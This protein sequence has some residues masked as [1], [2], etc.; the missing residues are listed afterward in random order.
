M[1]AK[2]LVLVLS[3]I[4]LICLFTGYGVFAQEKKVI[5][6]GSPQKTGHILVDAS[7]KFKEL[8]EKGSGGRIEVQVQPGVT[9][10]EEVNVWCSKGKVE[11]QAA[12]GRPLEVSAPQYFFFNAPYVMKDFDHFM[13][14]WEGNL[15]KKARE[16]LEKNGNQVS[17]GIVYRGLRQT[18]SKKPLY[19]PVDVYG[20]KLRLPPVKTWIAVWKEIGA[21]PISIPL[22]ELYKSLKEGKA[23][24]SEGDLPQI[25]SFK[26]DEV[27]THLTITNHQVQAG[28]ITINKTFFDGLSKADQQ[29][30]LKSAKDA[31]NWANDKIKKGESALLLELQ[32]KGMQVVIPDAESFREKG[33]PAVEELFKKEWPVTTWA[34]V[35]AK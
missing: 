13:R 11:I 24:A 32:R 20:L 33:K 5:R 29:L 19:T 2:R 30:I 35:L 18:T 23:E 1:R 12:G 8:V 27:Q 6:L 31:S 28:W 26:L 21:D 34:E 9:S 4:A 14:V 10:E 22:P 7:E 16:Q 15:G 17:L 25:A 3:V